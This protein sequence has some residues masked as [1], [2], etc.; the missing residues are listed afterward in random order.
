MRHPSCSASASPSA[1]PAP[2]TPTTPVFTSSG[3]ATGP[4]PVDLKTAA[5]FVI[6]AKSGISTVPSSS[7]TGD[8]GVSP[9][10]ATALTGFS[11]AYTAGS[12]S[13]TSSQVTGACFAA[14]YGD[15][16]PAKLTQAVHD[17][18]AAYTKAAGLAPPNYYNFNSAQLGGQTLSPG[19][20]N[21]N[22]GV[23]AANDVTLSGG[24]SDSF[25]F[26]INGIL[27]VAS[28][29]KITLTGGLLPQNVFWQ[30]TGGAT[31]GTHASIEG[32]I[33]SATTVI[34]KTGASLV[35]RA[36]AQ[37]AVTLQIVTVTGPPAPGSGPAVSAPAVPQ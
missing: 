11:L 27:T 23:N 29:K 7:I 10:A 14:S 19:I 26:Q 4:G 8:I 35:G 28:G 13:S 3:G 37:T 5:D 17:M 21:W 24:A 32:I 20:Y 18:E 31:L 36:F 15:G 6:L 2:P 22:S 25:V 33:G 16:T 34:L 1:P 12:A 9:I 30:V